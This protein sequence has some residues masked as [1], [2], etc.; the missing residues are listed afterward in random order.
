MAREKVKKRKSNIAILPDRVRCSVKCKG[1]M[2][3][4]VYEEIFTSR[5]ATSGKMIDRTLEAIKHLVDPRLKVTH[6][7]RRGS[8]TFRLAGRIERAT[9]GDML[10]TEFFS[11]GTTGNFTL[12]DLLILGAMQASRANRLSKEAGEAGRTK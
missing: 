5:R 10:A 3:T 2:A 8:V 4:L 11:W 7:R 9:V 6:R 12:K 1:K